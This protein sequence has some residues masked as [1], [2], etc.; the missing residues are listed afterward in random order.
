MLW[1]AYLPLSQSRSLSL[2]V[3]EIVLDFSFPLFTQDHLLFS[4]LNR[5]LNTTFDL[6]VDYGRKLDEFKE[7]IEYLT[8]RRGKVSGGLDIPRHIT[9]RLST[10]SR[11]CHDI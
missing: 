4:F 2:N 1:D 6:G 7:R 10:I 11:P 3:R 8:V 5:F 9:D